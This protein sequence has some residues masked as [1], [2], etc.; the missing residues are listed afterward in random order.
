MR[1]KGKALLLVRLEGKLIQKARFA[2]GVV[3]C[4]FFFFS[5]LFL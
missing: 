3:F 1:V 2:V 5:F 4:L